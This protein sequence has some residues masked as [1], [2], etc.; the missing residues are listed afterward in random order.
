MDHP[1][2]SSIEGS[3]REDG[4]LSDILDRFPHHSDG[5]PKMRLSGADFKDHPASVC[6]KLLAGHDHSDSGQEEIFFGI[7]G[8][9]TVLIG[10]KRE[11]WSIEPFD[12]IFIPP[13][14]YHNL[15]NE[16]NM[17]LYVLWIQSPA[18]WVFDKHPELKELAKEG[19]A[20][21]GER[22]K[23]IGDM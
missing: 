6:V 19:K 12:A 20:K 14:T 13:G 16:S 7:M 9:G 23:K 22:D 3:L 1:E 15:L 10:E 21:G 8:K 11:K 2:D 5:D 4:R 17:P 18:G